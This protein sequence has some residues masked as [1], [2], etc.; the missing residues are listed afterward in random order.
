MGWLYELCQ[1]KV[2]LPILVFDLPVVHG[3]H[4]SGQFLWSV[5][6]IIVLL[7]D[8]SLLQVRRF[9]AEVWIDQIPRLITSWFSL[10]IASEWEVKLLSN[11]D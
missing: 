3:G 7:R 6:F 8:F 5:F 2:E 4:E 10:G 1:L 11:K 9:D